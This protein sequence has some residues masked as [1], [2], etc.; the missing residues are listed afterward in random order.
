M[1][2]L[3]KCDRLRDIRQNVTEVQTGR[4]VELRDDPL[5]WGRSCQLVNIRLSRTE[6]RLR[7]EQSRRGR[8][9]KRCAAGWRRGWR[10]WRRWRRRSRVCTDAARHSPAAAS[11]PAA[12]TSGEAKHQC[13]GCTLSQSR[14]TTCPHAVLPSHVYECRSN[15]LTKP[16]VPRGVFAVQMTKV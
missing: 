4:F 10:R 9:I 2:L 12:A 13:Q 15:S 14:Y 3:I 6:R 8:G 7:Q 16:E 1:A 11:A 5:R